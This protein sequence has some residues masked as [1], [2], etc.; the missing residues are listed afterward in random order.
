MVRPGRKYI[1]LSET[2]FPLRSGFLASC[3]VDCGG[4]HAAL[5]SMPYTLSFET[6]TKLQ[7]LGLQVARTV[8]IWPADSQRVA[9]TVKGTANGSPLTRPASGLFTTT[10]WTATASAWT[11]NP[12]RSLMCRR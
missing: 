5:L 4:I 2:A 1:V 8:R 12:R 6:L 3:S 9:S 11:A 10:R 7:Q